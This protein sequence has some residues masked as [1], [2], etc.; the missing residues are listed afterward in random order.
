MEDFPHTLH[1]PEPE[2]WF[3]NTGN[4]AVKW[5]GL[6][7]CVGTVAHSSPQTIAVY[8]IHKIVKRE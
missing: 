5:Q 6:F 2:K 3:E 7:L 8:M 1:D 4:K